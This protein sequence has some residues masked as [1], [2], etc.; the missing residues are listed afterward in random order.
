MKFTYTLDGVALSVAGGTF[1][2]KVEDAAGVALFTKADGV[3]DK[4][5]AATGII[6]VPILEA[7]SNQTPK[8]YEGEVKTVFSGGDIDKTDDFDFVV[9]EAINA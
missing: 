3:F 9:E 4:T 7:D 1:T 2:L 8:T 5:D 6:L